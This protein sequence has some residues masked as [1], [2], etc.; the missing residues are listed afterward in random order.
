MAAG[1]CAAA[2]ALASAACSDSGDEPGGGASAGTGP[3]A[4]SRYTTPLKGICPDTVVV[5]TS[6]WPDVSHGY[7][8]QL[9][10]PDP[11]VEKKA[12]RVVGP[13]GGTG[14]RLEIRAGGP[15]VSFQPV[16]SILA[17]RDDTLLGYVDTDEAVQNSK[18][19]PTV[20]V[21][22]PSEKNPLVFLWGDPAWDFTDVAAIGRSGAP[23]LVTEGDVYP[24]VF[25][26]EGLLDASKVDTSY[27]GSPDRFVAADGKIVQVGFVTNEPYRLLHDVKEW[28]KP[29][30]YLLLA[31]EYPVYASALSIRRDKLEGSRA[32]LSKLVPL[33]QRAQRDY[34]TDPGA[35]NKLMLKAAGTL[36]TGGYGLSPG[37][38]ADGNAKQ[39]D[40]GLVA[41]GRDGVLGSFDTTRVRQL[42]GRLAPVFEA[43]GTAPKP[44][45]TPADLVTN[46]FLD[47]SVSLR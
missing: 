32:C 11:A 5:Q 15:A 24:E 3:A 20:A 31:G 28:G 44:G 18:S 37:L 2:L 9:L 43:R 27:Q 46:D 30:E 14:V 10:G 8:Y 36:D 12:N 1:A 7:T 16:S 4:A 6:W 13:L 41:D 34:Q 39:K 35:A 22:A 25:E 23:V 45:L 26:R 47:P 40:L 38:L 19:Q 29:V 33:F 17:Q 21:F 42:I